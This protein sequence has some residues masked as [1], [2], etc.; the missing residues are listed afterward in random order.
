MTVQSNDLAQDLRGFTGD[1]EMYKQP[2][3]LGGMIYT[4]GVEY[5]CEKAGA[6]WFLDIIGTEIHKQYD[7]GFISL[8]VKDD[9]GTITVTDGNEEVY[10]TRK[11]DYTDAPEGD[12]K[13]WYMNQTLLLPSE[14]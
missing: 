1:L 3:F 12:W 14:Y 9:K 11:I 7:E 13:F 5:F 4:K 6:Y 2:D 8:D 10:Y